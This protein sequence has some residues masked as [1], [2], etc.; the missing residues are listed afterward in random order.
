MTV[1]PRLEALLGDQSGEL[2]ALAQ[3]VGLEEPAA[4]AQ[5][6]LVR[7]ALVRLVLA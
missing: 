7:P 1:A 6:V 3:Q 2:A 4:P 5:Q